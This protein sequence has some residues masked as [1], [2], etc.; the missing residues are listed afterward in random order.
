SP[1]L[2]NSHA[3][4]KAAT[5]L[6]ID[7]HARDLNSTLP[8]ESSTSTSNTVIA[9]VTK[10]KPVIMKKSNI[11][12]SNIT[13]SNITKSN[14]TK[15]DN[16]KHLFPIPDAKIN[17][18]KVYA[19]EGHNFCKAYILH[20]FHEFVPY[21]ITSILTISSEEYSISLLRKVVIKKEKELQMKWSTL[22]EF[23]AEKGIQVICWAWGVAPAAKTITQSIKTLPMASVQLL[24]VAF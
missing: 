3:V 24:L 9:K 22:P 16:S 21:F 17:F 5:Q 12:K 13:K 1:N 15:L 11:T 20:M 6:I 4:A 19:D 14:T 10:Q 18:S 8:S 7:G 2:W 23:L